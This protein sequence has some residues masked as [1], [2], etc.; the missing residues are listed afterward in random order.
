MLQNMT[1]VMSVVGKMTL[2]S[3]SSPTFPAVQTK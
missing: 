2:C 1:S 3:F